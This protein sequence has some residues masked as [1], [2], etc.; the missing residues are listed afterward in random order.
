MAGLFGGRA[1]RRPAGGAIGLP[2]VEAPFISPR[3]ALE[4]GDVHK[5]DGKPLVISR[6]IRR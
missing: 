2:G 5:S 6:K 1:P 3:S 4:L